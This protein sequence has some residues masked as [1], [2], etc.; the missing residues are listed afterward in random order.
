MI[1]DN[2]K[3]INFYNLNEE[4]MKLVFNWRNNELIRKWMYNQ[5]IIEL[6]KHLEFIKNLKNDKKKYISL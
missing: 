2:F 1:E 6:D 5:E 4:E 3:L